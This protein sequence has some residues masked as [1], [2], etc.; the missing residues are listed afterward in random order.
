[1][2]KLIL[3]T[4]VLCLLMACATIPTPQVPPPGAVI[5][6]APPQLVV[7]STF[8]FRETNILK[9]SGFT[10]TFVV[11]KK[12]TYAGKPAYWVRIDRGIGDKARKGDTYNVYDLDLNLMA[13][14]REGKEVNTFSPCVKRFS[15]PIFVGKEWVIRYRFDDRVTGRWNDGMSGKAKVESY[16]QTTVP[17]GTFETFKIFS[18]VVQSETEVIQYY[19]PL[20]GMFIKE[21][22]DQG[23]H[24]RL[25][26]GK[27]VRELIQYNIPKQ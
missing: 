27:W 11:E 14:F 10:Y 3:L 22:L 4:G 9:K 23:P 1:M 15:W 20:V 25:G 21:E 17:L 5:A 7:G 8:V 24:H 19:S 6:E 26:V 16:A 13:E 18:H 12:D 2:K